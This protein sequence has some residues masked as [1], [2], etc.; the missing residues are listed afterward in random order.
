MRSTETVGIDPASAT[1]AGASQNTTE[2]IEKDVPPVREPELS[3]TGGASLC[4]WYDFGFVVVMLIVA[5][6]V[7]V[8]YYHQPLP[9]TLVRFLGMDDTVYARPVP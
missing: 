6:L 8:F 3:M 7:W 1:S 5:A 2:P 4:R 9:A